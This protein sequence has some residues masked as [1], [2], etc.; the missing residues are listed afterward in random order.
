MASPYLR[1]NP[2][3]RSKLFDEE[4][5]SLFPRA[6]RVASCAPISAGLFETVTKLDRTYGRRGCCF[7]SYGYI[8]ILL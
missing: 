6:S 5:R 7:G 8:V 2:Y 4:G 3:L 1:S